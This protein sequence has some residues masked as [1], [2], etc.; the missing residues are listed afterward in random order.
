MGI[1]ISVYIYRLSHTP[2]Q[3][4]AKQ[5]Y[6]FLC[7]VPKSKPYF[8]FKLN[9][10]HPIN[11]PSVEQWNCGMKHTKSKSSTTTIPPSQITNYYYKYLFSYSEILFKKKKNEY[12]I[13]L[14][15]LLPI[16]IRSTKCI[17]NIQSSTTADTYTDIIHTHTLSTIL[18]NII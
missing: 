12:V 8:P 6:N 1:H 16:Q 11:W 5:R 14:F 9:K 17:I 4:R 3:S 7:H 10:F 18:S 2:L 15:S 13:L